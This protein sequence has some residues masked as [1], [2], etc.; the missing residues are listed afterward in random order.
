MGE[1]AQ[2][3][4]EKGRGRKIASRTINCAPTAP[5]KEK[6][7]KRKKKEKRK[8]TFMGTDPHRIYQGFLFFFFSFFI[9]SQNKIKNK[10]E[11]EKKYL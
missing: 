5:E 11:E 10:K 2:T 9:K 1:G 7:K 6:E 4:K 3:N 8:E